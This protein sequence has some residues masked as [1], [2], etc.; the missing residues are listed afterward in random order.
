MEWG[1]SL[2][3]NNP[4]VLRKAQNE[5]D[6]H[7]GKD[8]LIEESDIANLPYLR[9]IVNETLRLYPAGPLAI[10]HESS[11]DCVVGGYNIPR[12]T[13]LIYNLWAIHH[14]PKLW[15][16]PESFNPERFEGR[17]ATRDGFKLL[18]FGSG[19]R[20]CPGEGLASRLVTITLGLLIQ[21][22]DWEVIIEDMVDMTEAPG[23]TMPKAQ[24]LVV[25]CKSRVV[26]QNLLLQT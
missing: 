5:I 6:M 15:P 18:P 20:R 11:K 1:L 25:K 22:F 19:R 12:G 14:D 9:C 23:L 16:D 26:M 24:P 2:L 8:R 13:M 3:L 10:A 21:C 4:H 7:V 17:E